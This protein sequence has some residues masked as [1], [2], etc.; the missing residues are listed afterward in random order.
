MSPSDRVCRR[1]GSRRR[2]IAGIGL[3]HDRVG[4]E[5]RGRGRLG[6]LGRE[7]PV[8]EM[9]SALTHQP[10]RGGFPEGGR[11][12]VAEGDFV[13]VG[14]GEQLAEAAA[15]PPDQIP[16]RLLAMRGPHQVGALSKA[17]ERLGPHLGR[18]AAKTAVAGLELG[19]NLRGS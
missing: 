13:T 7:L 12:A 1:V 18:T 19:G 11:A 9:E 17:G 10:S 2:G 4:E 3:D 16:H 5:R 6:E 14:K 15:H 8:G